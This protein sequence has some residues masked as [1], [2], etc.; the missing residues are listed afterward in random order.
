MSG[1]GVAIV[2]LVVA[3][4][5]AGTGIFAVSQTTRQSHQPATTTPTTQTL[6]G[7]MGPQGGERGLEGPQGIQGEKG[8]SGTGG[9]GVRGATGATGANGQ[10]GPKGDTGPQG[11][12]VQTSCIN[13]TSCVGLQ[14]ANAT[15]QDG[16]VSISG[17]AKSGT[18]TT[19]RVYERPHKLMIYYG[20]PQGVNGLWNSDAAAQTF[21][22][23]DYVVFGTGLQVPGST[24]HNSTVEIVSKMRTLNKQVKVFG[25]INIGVSI[26]NQPES[27]L[28]TE[29]DQWKATGADH[30]FFDLAGYDYNVP[31]ARLNSLLDYAH[32][33]DMQVMVNAW[34][35]ADV[36]GSDVNPT[37]NPTGTATHMNSGDFY[38]LESWIVHTAAYASHN[39]YATM[40]DLKT[41]ADSAVSF[42]NSLGVKIMNTNI[43]DFS[44]YS[45][46][47]ENKYFKMIEAAS[48]MYSMDGY[49]FG[50]DN[51]SAT[52]PNVNVVKPV[53][54]DPNYA[55]YFN[56][57]APY[58]INGPWTEMTRQDSSVVFHNDFQ[59]NTH[60]YGN[61]QT[62][63][64]K[65][66]NIDTMNNDVGIGVSAPT[67]KL[68]VMTSAN[69][70]TTVVV[71]A[72][73]GQ[74]ADLLSVQSSTGTPLV[75]V[76]VDGSLTASGPGFGLGS[77]T[78]GVDVA[79]TQSST[80]L[81]VTFGTVYPSANY[82]VLCT[83][84]YSTT[85][86][87]TNKTTNGFT[88]NFGT[89]A[90]ANASVSW[91]AIR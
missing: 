64:L 59:T 17:D 74:T 5:A 1:K 76:A 37:Y 68:H 88:L 89:A 52:A 82:A 53:E 51:Y 77:N 39:G 45:D 83:P 41:R 15:V 10:T 81:N 71:Q 60:W 26:G 16:N 35:P 46:E 9:T 90:P 25:Y 38:L 44:A 21:A 7:P 8:V 42:R 27:E 63:Q 36:M 87:V 20:I 43:V 62:T 73:S 31:R 49:G 18:V 32:S 55:S 86:Y 30:I 29:I 67:G 11:A 47:E 13:G 54:Y 40:S 69:G 22:R 57:S 65:V 23:W 34:V 75:R 80:T 14:G 3:L 66:I 56:P 70:T 84:N 50:P 85:C 58:T 91:M 24:Y 6:E 33:K 79:I 78:R 61:S 48:I 4:L 12:S 28:R 2:A 72:K 19:D